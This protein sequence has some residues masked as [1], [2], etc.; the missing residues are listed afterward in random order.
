MTSPADRALLLRLARNA[1]A[2]HVAGGPAWTS[3]TEG[4]SDVLARLA[5]V[6]VSIHRHGDL[7]GCIG[8]IAADLRL[9]EVIAQCAVGACSRDP[10]FKPLTG[11]ELDEI[12]IEL[13]LLG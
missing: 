3:T 7:R 5:G 11:A 13:S 10:R 8:H 9:D 4:D 6:F 1:I 12:D 2:A